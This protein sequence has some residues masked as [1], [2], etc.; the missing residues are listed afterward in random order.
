MVIPTEQVVAGDVVLI[1]CLT[2]EEITE[3]HRVRPG[4]KSVS[5]ERTVVPAPEPAATPG[6]APATLNW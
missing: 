1:T 6:D 4:I 5:S 2:H 3:K